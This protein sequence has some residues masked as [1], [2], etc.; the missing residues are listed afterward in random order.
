MVLQA[1]TSEQMWAGVLDT[2]RGFADTAVV[3]PV[4]TRRTLSRRRERECGGGTSLRRTHWR[5]WCRPASGADARAAQRRPWKQRRAQC[6]KKQE[7]KCGKKAGGR[8]P[9]AFARQSTNH[10]ANAAPAV[11]YGEQGQALSQALL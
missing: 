2:T 4:P 6:I 9:D 1:D 7:E 5:K 11:L 8:K 10:T 3:V